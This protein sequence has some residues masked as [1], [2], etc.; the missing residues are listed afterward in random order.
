MPSVWAITEPPEVELINQPALSRIHLP[1]VIDG[2][3]LHPCF[4][5]LTF[6]S[7]IQY[8]LQR[9]DLAV[10]HLQC[11][12]ADRPPLLHARLKVKQTMNILGELFVQP[13]VILQAQFVQV[14]LP[15]LRECD[16]PP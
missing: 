9:F 16:R 7:L 15:R 6:L 14:T 2:Q 4:Y 5:S 12:A 10:D 8:R 13:L 1:P 11:W 3:S